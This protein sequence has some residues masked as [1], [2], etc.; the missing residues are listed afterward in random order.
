[1]SDISTEKIQ[2]DVD[3]LTEN[4]DYL[5]GHLPLVAQILIDSGT[6]LEKDASASTLSVIW[7]QVTRLAQVLAGTLTSETVRANLGENMIIEHVIRLL[8]LSTESQLDFRVQALR[9]L[10]NACIDYDDNRKRV[11]EAGAVQ[12]VIPFLQESQNP[13][14]TKVACGFCLNSSMDYD[15]IQKAISET[16]GV[17]YMAHLLQPARMDHGEEVMVTIAAK[18]LDNLMGD[19]KDAGRKAFP[20][21]CVPRLLEMVKYEWQVDRFENLDLLES[22]V[23]VL[24]QLI[25]EDEPVQNAVIDSGYLSVLL[26]FM[27]KAELKDEDA[28]EEDT[29][30]FEQIQTSVSKVV[31][32]AT[33]SDSKLEELYADKELLSR[34]M[35]WATSKSEILA[36]CGIYVIGNLARTDEHCIDL[37]RTHHLEKTLLSAFELTDKAIFRYAVLGCLKHL[38]LPKEN[39]TVIGEA[40]AIAIVSPTLES[41]NDMLKRNQFLT[42]GIIKLLC[43]N[44]YGNATKVI[45]GKLVN[46]KMDKSP[47]DLVM[48]CL[49]RFDDPAAK[50]EATRILTNLIKSV[51]FHQDAQASSTYRQK[52][53][54]SSIIQAISEMTRTSKF[55]IL[56]ND[57]LVALSLIFADSRSDT[58]K[59]MLPEALSI[60]T[61]EPPKLPLPEQDE[62]QEE[63]PSEQQQQPQETRSFLEVLTEL[64]GPE[65]KMPMEIRCNGCVLIEKIASA[66]EAVKDTVALEKVKTASH[67]QLQRLLKEEQT[68]TSSMIAPIVQK[69]L[70]VLDGSSD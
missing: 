35:S 62:E 59:E 66:A 16:E 39:K 42:I 43:A 37:V 52:L 33:Y 68:L 34:F 58:G 21:D 31:V 18:A 53:T 65:G 11:L 55:P 41:T 5:V 26:D 1:M 30:H 19:G 49:G 63:D 3:N 14:L 12:L 61:G 36:Q 17:S 69:A 38:C 13:D 64:V 9:V 54:K 6:L 56:R 47:L 32:C 70:T 60:V 50:S 44:E 10:G 48:D 51:W 67:E 46:S 24:L 57:G 27:E 22:L 28:D 25:A 7:N 45:S 4:K 23:D 20:L 15:P 40:D 29:K 8:K 2:H